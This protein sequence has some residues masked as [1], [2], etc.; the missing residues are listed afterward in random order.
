MFLNMQD[1]HGIVTGWMTY[2]DCAIGKAHLM[3]PVAAAPPD[4]VKLL[5]E[6]QPLAGKTASALEPTFTVH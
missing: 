6:R 4:G 1:D 5:N 2:H 3:T